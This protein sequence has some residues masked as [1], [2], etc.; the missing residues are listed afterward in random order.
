MQFKPGLNSPLDTNAGGE[1]T[2]T[3]IIPA[4][5]GNYV[6]ESKKIEAEIRLRVEYVDLQYQVTPTTIPIKVM[7]TI[8]PNRFPLYDWLIK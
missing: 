1:A 2:Y 5:Y 6:F 3:E 8:I 4:L 7:A